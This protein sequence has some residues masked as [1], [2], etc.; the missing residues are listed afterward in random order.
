M[1]TF[2][3]ATGS[4]GALR[5]SVSYAQSGNTTTFTIDLHVINTNSAT[6]FSSASWSANMAGLARSGTFSVSGAGTYKIGTWK[7][8]KEHTA[9]GNLAAQSFTF[10]IGATGT[11]GVGGPTTVSG[12]VSVPRIPKVPS[13]PAAPSGITP[14][15]TSITFTPGSVFDNGGSAITQY[16]Y[17]LGGSSAFA[18]IYKSWTGTIAKQTA[19][20]LTPGISHWIRSRARNAVGWG[21]WSPSRSTTTLSVAPPSFSV[22]AAPHGRS[23]FVTLGPPSTLPS[24]SA[25]R[26]Q[27]RQVGGAT[28]AVDLAPGT[29]WPH[30]I[31]D[32]VL[33]GRTYEWRAAALQGT[34]VSNYTAWTTLEQ[35]SPNLA[36]GVYFD[37]SFGDTDEYGYMWAS[38]AHASVSRMR[39]RV[40]THY[41][42]H[43]GARTFTLAL[44]QVES[45]TAGKTM[46]RGD[47]VQ[48]DAEAD[49]AGA[50]GSKTDGYATVAANGIYT[51]SMFVKLEH[52][53]MWLRAVIWWGDGSGA[54]LGVSEGAPKLV[55]AGVW[56]R[57]QVTGQAPAGAVRATVYF[58]DAPDGD[59]WEPWAAGTTFYLERL[60]LEIGSM[61]PYFDGD[62]AVDSYYYDWEGVPLD[63]VSVASEVPEALLSDPF[64]DPD[65]APVP[66]PPMPP[67]I[68]DDAV[69]EV[70]QWRRYWLRVPADEVGRWSATI[71]TIIISSG[72]HDMRQIRVRY[73]PNPDDLDVLDVDYLGYDSEQIISYMPANA[74]FE[75]N[76]I[77]QRLRGR[78]G[79]AEWRELGNLLYATGGAPATWS[80]LRGNI[81]YL[82]AFD[83][84]IDAPDGNLSTLVDLTRRF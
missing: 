48:Q 54:N 10:S 15:A 76:G 82:V 73:Y 47:V 3:K 37:G 61:S 42:K 50:G 17:Q 19:T 66:V 62:R 34:Y 7:V 26:V 83:V 77:S 64:A 6:W 65:V 57:I 12:S 25:Y 30:E 63:S 8:T 74:T 46:L 11:S 56:T 69:I 79:S 18:T 5:I 67:P 80:E 71:P 16:Q 81:P 14:A 13:A 72:A 45:D 36:A 28:V 52:Q 60:Q 21:P 33:P 41:A 39:G 43:G 1:P 2:S 29:A 75:L 4:S 44:A 55:H 40:P 32:Q 70:G 84:P 23:V 9:A 24:P 59:S 20:G 68:V 35:P 49:P 78:I 31:S 38:T 58:L 22:S 27:Y 53:A 51:G